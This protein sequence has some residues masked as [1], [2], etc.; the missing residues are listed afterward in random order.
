MST[1]IYF[2]SEQID[3]SQHRYNT[4]NLFLVALLSGVAAADVAG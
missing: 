3:C 4:N 2:F 1:I